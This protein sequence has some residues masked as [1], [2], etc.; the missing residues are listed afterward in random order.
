MDWI[1]DT[2]SKDIG[3]WDSVGAHCP[4][5]CN[6]NSEDTQVA[7]VRLREG[8]E[9]AMKSR[10]PRS[11]NLHNASNLGASQKQSQKMRIG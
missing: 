11:A 6:E 2:L 3:G 8:V 1:S 4:Y 5:C 10:A 9:M 7:A